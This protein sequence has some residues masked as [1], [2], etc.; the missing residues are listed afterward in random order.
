MVILVLLLSKYFTYLLAKLLIHTC[1]GEAAVSWN[2]GHQMS[3]ESLSPKE[4]TGSI[5][6]YCLQLSDTNQISRSV[7]LLVGTQDHLLS[8]A[9]RAAKPTMGAQ[10]PPTGF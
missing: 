9:D 10:A 7:I 5:E 6:R 2:R 8:C 4:A 1:R 3:P